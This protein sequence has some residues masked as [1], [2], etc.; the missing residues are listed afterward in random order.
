MNDY[1]E[2]CNW[3]GENKL[4][5]KELGDNTF[6]VYHPYVFHRKTYGEKN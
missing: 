4:V 1:Y 2:T 6:F 5:D 3:I